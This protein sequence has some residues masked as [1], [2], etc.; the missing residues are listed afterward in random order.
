M[1]T[2]DRT[3]CQGC[4][5]R[6]ISIPGG[7]IKESMAGKIKYDKVTGLCA[8]KEYLAEL[9]FNLIACRGFSRE[10]DHIF[11]I[12]PPSFRI[13]QQF[14]QCASIGLGKAQGNKVVRIIVMIYTNNE[15]VAM[16][17]IYLITYFLF[18]FSIWYFSKIDYTTRGTLL[19]RER[20]TCFLRP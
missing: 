3:I 12:P 11:R 13:N 18:V 2:R 14:I 16:F 5:Q 17:H 4:P 10:K 19:D 6:K 1:Q 15:S 9:T 20:D 8:H 7:G